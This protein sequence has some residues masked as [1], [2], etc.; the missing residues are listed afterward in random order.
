MPLL[1]AITPVIETS[2]PN[3]KTR[4]HHLSSS[5][6]SA[7]RARPREKGQDSSGRPNV[8]A[9]IEMIGTRIVEVDGA[10]DQAKPEEL[11]IKIQI[12]L[13]ITGNRGDV[14]DTV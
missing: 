13:R 12:A 8:I 2:R 3:R 4:C 6:R 14:M 5:A 7:T 1:E 10:F 9:K 11:G